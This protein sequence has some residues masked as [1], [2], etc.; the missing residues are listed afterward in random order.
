MRW[1]NVSDSNSSFAP[2]AVQADH[3]GHSGRIGITSAG[4]HTF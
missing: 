2:V 3:S 1:W 4:P